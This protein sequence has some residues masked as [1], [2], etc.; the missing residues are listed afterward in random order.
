VIVRSV[1]PQAPDAASVREAAEALLFGGVVAFPTD[2]VYGLSCLLM[3]PAAVE[4]VYRL[5]QRPAHL[6]VIALIPEPDAILPLVD[7]VPEVAEALMARFWPGPLS[8]IF[9]A[10]PLVPPRVAGER[11]TVALRL[12]RHALCESLL[13]AV[14]G[15]VVSSSANLSGQPPCASAG[16]I[17]RTFGNQIDVVL[18][19]GVVGPTPPSTVVDVSSGGL[20]VVRAGAVDVSEFLPKRR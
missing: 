18:D 13:A 3:D 8:I 17:I 2:T 14:S 19:G 12:P 9:R 7:A 6:S 10:S 15:P 5:K 20:E 1:D 16:E 11:R 4:F